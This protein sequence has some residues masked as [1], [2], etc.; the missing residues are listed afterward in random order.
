MQKF[1]FSFD[2]QNLIINAVNTSQ[3]YRYH[4]TDIQYAL[5]IPLL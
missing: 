1:E 3:Q 4:I 2:E 5:F